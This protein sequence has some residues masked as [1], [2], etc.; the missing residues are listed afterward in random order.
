[1]LITDIMTAFKDGK[2]LS[3]RSIWANTAAATGLLSGFLAAA[4]QIAKALGYDLGLTDDTINNLAAGGVALALVITNLVHVAANPAAGLPTKPGA[5][6]ADQ[7]GT[8]G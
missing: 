8:G 6:L 4:V 7:S 5:G 2:A 3:N 1:M